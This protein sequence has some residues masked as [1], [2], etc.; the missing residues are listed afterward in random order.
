[1]ILFV[2]I[3]S[4]IVAMGVETG[5]HVHL[6]VRISPSVCVSEVVGRL[7][8]RSTFDLWASHE[9]V[10]KKHYWSGKRLLWGGGFFVDSVGRVPRGVVLDYVVKDRFGDSV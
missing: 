10:L 6:V 8:Q 1:V 9:G 5:N 7:K 3:L 4:S 2:C